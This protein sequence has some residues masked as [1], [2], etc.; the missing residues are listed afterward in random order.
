MTT[1][2]RTASAPTI[3]VVDDVPQNLQLLGGMLRTSGYK[4][5]PVASGKLAIQAVSIEPPDLVLLDINMPEMSG[6]E[7]CEHLKAVPELAEIPVIFISA[8]TDVVDKVRAFAVGGLDF[9]T[10]PFQF[11]EVE[12]RVRLHLD[13]R[14]QKRDLR[15]SYHRLQKLEELRDNLVHMIVHDLRSPLTSVVGYLRLLEMSDEPL[16]PSGRECVE[17]ARS[18]A[19]LVVRMVSTLLDVSRME[20]G[21]M[22]LQP[23]EC[24]L[25]GLTRDVMAKLNVLSGRH[26]LDLN[27]PDQPVRVTADA[28]LILRV[29]YNLLA[30][31]VKFTP[32]SGDI[33]VAIEQVEN[34]VRFSVRDNGPGIP[35]EYHGRIFEKFGQ[36]DAQRR[37]STGLGLTFCKLAVESHGGRIGVASRAGEGSTFWFELPHSAPSRSV[38]QSPT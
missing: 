35:P 21:E 33:R 4:V 37:D 15:E 31:A 10:K 14:Q 28:D 9:V 26:T 5:R 18:S 6:Y 1:S 38:A 23:K 13:L 16:S 19:D 20:S 22:R 7:V 17:I 8:L 36:V 29:I 27:G 24:D 25:M 2:T 30:N 12:A 11:E 34:G 32:D 3:M